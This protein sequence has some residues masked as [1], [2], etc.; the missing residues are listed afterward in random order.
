[1]SGWIKKIALAVISFV[2]LIAVGGIALLYI[3]FSLIHGRDHVSDEVLIQNLGE[4]IVKYELLISMFREDAPASVIHPT[5]MSPDHVVDDERWRKY[6]TLFDELE[7][8]AGIRTW[9][10]ESIRFI[11]TAQGLVTGG[12]MKGY[13]YRPENPFPQYPSLNQIPD[14]LES[15]VTGYRKINEQWYIMF[16]WDD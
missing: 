4:N 9:G 13:V 14:D 15:N 2:A 6:K 12:S 7:L 16:N 3:I 5:W 8:D 1:M 10:G 11:S